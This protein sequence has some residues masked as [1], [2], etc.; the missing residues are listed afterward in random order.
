M[1]WSRRG[2]TSSIPNWSLFVSMV[3]HSSELRCS[4]TLC[5]DSAV[6]ID[7]VPH[8]LFKTNLPWWQSA[9]FHFFNLVLGSG[10]HSVEAQHCGSCLQA[11][12]PFLAHQLSLHFSRQLL[13]QNLR[14]LGPPTSLPRRFPLG[15]G[16]SGWVSRRPS[17][18]MVPRTLLWF[19][20]IE[21]PW[22]NW[23]INFH[24]LG[25]ALFRL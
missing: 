11:R 3:I 7:S 12:G 6:G 23:D 20:T 5:F 4:L 16:F 25:R 24:K 10:P 9:V 15:C 19:S 14:A 8:S 22:R 13:F 21:V 1:R 17:H 2:F 18:I